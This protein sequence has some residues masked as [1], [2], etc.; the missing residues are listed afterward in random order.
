MNFIISALTDVGL[1]KETNQDSLLVRTLNTTKGRMV[2]AV[3]CDGMGG[4]EKGEV[5]SASVIHAFSEWMLHSL[6]EIL[7]VPIEDSAIRSEWTA[8]A[9]QMNEKIKAYGHQHN[10]KLGTTVST[11][12]LTSSRYYIMNVGDSRVYEIKEEVRQI[13]DDHTLVEREVKEGKI[14]KEEAK[15]DKRRN[16]L[17]KCIGASQKLVP[18]FFFGE[19]LLDAVYMLCTDGFRHEITD[20][21]IATALQPNQML[22][23]MDMEKGM[24]ELIE[25]NKKRGEKDNISVITIRT[26]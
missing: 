12:L 13:T 23:V 5:A 2:F 15:S 25:M 17:L 19:S 20:D 14:S 7:Q 4:Y 22:S 9:E 26:F 1:K 11:L 21:E 10:I 3:L 16:I 24:G 18:D 6:P 8:I